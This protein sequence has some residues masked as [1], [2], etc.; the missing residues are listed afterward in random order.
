MFKICSSKGFHIVFPNGITL[1]TQFG[2]GN[3]CSNYNIEIGS[4][5]EMPGLLSPDAEIAI[6]SNKK[7]LTEEMINDIF[8]AEDSDDVLGNVRIDR[9]LQIF[10]WCRNHENV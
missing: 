8:K 3:Y 10:D 7:W 9:W 2:G 5:R 1:S 4:E 6:M